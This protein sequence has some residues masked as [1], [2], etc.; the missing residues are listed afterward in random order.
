LV[1]TAGAASVFTR[2]SSWSAPIISSSLFFRYVS[3]SGVISFGHYCDSVIKVAST[4]SENIDIEYTATDDGYIFTVQ[5][6][7]RAIKVFSYD[8]AP[9]AEEED[10]PHFN[11]LLEASGTYTGRYMNGDAEV[12]SSTAGTIKVYSATKG[13][14]YTIVSLGVSS[15]SAGYVIVGFDASNSPGVGEKADE[16]I[17]SGLSSTAS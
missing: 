3:K 15:P 14:K 6:S 12:K 10:L 13:K 4:T 9:V 1:R 16:K 2:S 5:Y 7:N 11:K 8:L 17:L